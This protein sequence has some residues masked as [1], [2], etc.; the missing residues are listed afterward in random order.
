[1]RLLGRE[2][3]SMATLWQSKILNK[4]FQAIMLLPTVFTLLVGWADAANSSATFK[5]GA[6]DRVE[7]IFDGKYSDSGCY[8]DTGSA[9]T[10][11]P[12]D[13][14]H[15]AKPHLVGLLT[16]NKNSC[17]TGI[18]KLCGEVNISS[19]VVSKKEFASNLTASSCFPASSSGLIGIDAID[20][21][22]WV[23]DFTSQEIS[24]IKK[25]P[26]HLKL[27]VLERLESGHMVI[28][29]SVS[30]GAERALLDSGWGDFGA[31]DSSYVLEHPKDFSCAN[32]A[33][34]LGEDACGKTGVVHRC[35]ILKIGIDKY[36]SHT[37]LLLDVYDFSKGGLSYLKERKISF[38]FG[39]KTMAGLVWFLDLKNN[40]WATAYPSLH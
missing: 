34:Q 40:L 22:I 25:I 3:K 19:L 32:E 21:K 7:C 5:L 14:F 28:P 18:T 33:I 23:F 11:L 35:K 39:H 38:L 4:N 13:L 8:I 6:D 26:P 24:E 12:A 37:G 2:I 20:Q 30:G 27:H 31:V 29:V 15:W 17:V 9:K 10:Q 36:S 1:M 16:P